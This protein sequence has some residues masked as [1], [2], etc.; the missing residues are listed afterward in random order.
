MFRTGRSPD[1]DGFTLIELL[2]ALA[3]LSIATV[4][5][6]AWVPS[7]EDRLAVDRSARQIERALSRAARD[8]AVTGSDQIVNFEASSH[9]PMVAVGNR[10]IELDPSVELRWLGASELGA[11]SEHSAIAFLATGGSSGGTVELRQG[12]AQTKIEIDWLSGRVRQ[13]GVGDDAP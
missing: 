8:A 9:P 13:T 6:V 7:L 5:I 1:D 3:L 12:K 4:I 11:D 2:V 10:T